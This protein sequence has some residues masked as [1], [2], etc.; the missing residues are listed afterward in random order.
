MWRIYLLGALALVR[1]SSGHGTEASAL[2]TGAIGIA[3]RFGATHHEAVTSS[4]LALTLVHLN[5]LEVDRAEAHL[6][7]AAGQN[8]SRLSSFV[9]LDIHRTLEAQLITVTEGPRRAL[10]ILH[11]PSSCVV[12]PHL[13]IEA[14]RAFEAHL[15]IQAG[16]LESARALLRGA[17]EWPGIPAPRIDLALAGGD[18]SAARRSLESWRPGTDDLVA[19]VSRLLR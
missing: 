11:E 3:E 9:F 18:L 5:R 15:R 10:S 19:A 8:A 16:E 2:A 6:A 12:E 17:G 14:N 13:L 1:A 4:R 7:L